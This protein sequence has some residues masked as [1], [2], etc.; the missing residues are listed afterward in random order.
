MKNAAAVLV[1]AVLC[2][3]P[4]RSVADPSTYET[5]LKMMSKVPE[6]AH[7]SRPGRYDQTGDAKAIAAGIA[8]A[9]DDGDDASLAVVFAAYESSNSLRDPSGECIGGDV[10]KATLEYQSWGPFQL[11]VHVASKEV[12]CAPQMAAATWIDS[13]ARSSKA[14][15]VEPSRGPPRVARFGLL[16]E[17]RGHQGVAPSD[18]RRRAGPRSCLSLTRRRASRRLGG[19][20]GR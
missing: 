17:P 3:A 1:L 6:K 2:V 4:S 9:T 13:D 20:R 19:E 5:V 16:H 10:D 14:L 15:R 18:A 8:A 11:N 12:A 7:P